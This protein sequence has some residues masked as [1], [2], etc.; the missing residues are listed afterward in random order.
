MWNGSFDK[1][2]YILSRPGEYEGK[3]ITVLGRA[4]S[5]F[6]LPFVGSIYK[7]DDGTGAIWVVSKLD[8]TPGRWFLYMEATV[9]SNLNGK[10]SLIDEEIWSKVM[11]S[12]PLGP[13]LYERKR[14]SIW[15]SLNSFGKHVAGSLL[16]RKGAVQ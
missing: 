10:E 13:I 12:R 6:S 5:A 16:T 15:A 1:V 9:A 3:S 2:E 8:Y 7:I 4:R 11:G 14:D